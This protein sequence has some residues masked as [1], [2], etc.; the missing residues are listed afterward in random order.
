MFKNMLKRAWLSTT[1]K[2]AKSI[3]IGL[4]LFAMANLVLAAITINQAVDASTTYAKE[5]LGGTIYLQ[6]DMDAL[7]E[8]MTAQMSAPDQAT[9]SPARVTRPSVPI[10]TATAIADSTYIKDYSYT[11]T[12]R[13]K[14]IS[15]TPIE[16]T[17][18]SFP[19]GG[20]FRAPDSTGSE[21][22][23]TADISIESANAFAFL[24]RVKSNTLEYEGDYFDEST[25]DGVMIS[26]EL[27]LAASLN[28][29]DQITL[30]NVYTAAEIPLTII[31]TY[32]VTDE[33]Y[34]EN[35]I[36][37]NTATTA[38][39]LDES[40]YNSGDYGVSS[41]TYYLT[42]AEHK[43]AFITEATAKYPDLTTDGLS[44]DIDTS[45][46]DQMV[47]PITSVGSF[48]TT[49]LIVVIIASVIIVT[50]IVTLNIRERRYEMGV[51]LSLGA[52]KLNILGQIFVE[53][54]LIGTIFFALSITTSTA[55][56]RSMGQGLLESQISMNQQET[57]QNFGRGQ[58]AGRP[59]MMGQMNQQFSP[60]QSAEVEPITTINIEAS[61]STYL[62]LFILGY[63]TLILALIIPSINIL[64]YQ[65]KQIL[66]GKE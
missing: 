33:T 20:N 35:L 64:R 50:L 54:V 16:S 28:I 27:A 1:R 45:A 14:A 5:S 63:F 42:N 38:K 21:S 22:T 3:L 19:G 34:D 56:A 65:P 59:G 13:A 51:L 53:L 37:M 15:F 58:N 25:D 47:G 7:R 32:T 26:T 36:Y 43:D 46:Y 62:I 40:T 4:I 10:T 61:P 23:I 49:I 30:Q 11:L 31:G 18:N 41:V 9:T 57:D 66:T 17:T 6:P 48:A 52:D 24:S 55:L 8:R 2:P 44:L 39:F 60:T 29:G 12:A